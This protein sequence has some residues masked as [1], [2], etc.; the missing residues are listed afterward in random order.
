MDQVLRVLVV[1]DSAYVRKAIKQMLS[2]SPF[3]EVVGIAHDGQ[4]A[5]EMVEQLRPDVVTC[6][7]IM[8]VMDGV[9]FVK[10][11]MS[12]RP[13]PIVVVSIANEGSELAL[14]ALDLGAVDFAQKPT[15]LATEKIFEVSDELIEKVKAAGSVPMARLQTVLEREPPQVSALRSSQAGLVDIVVLGISTGGP[16][17]LKYL[18]PQLPANFP[19]PI[20]MVMHMP[21]GYTEMYA[22]KLNELCEIK[23]SEARE[24]SLITP[25]TVLLAPAGRH[26][27]LRRQANEEVVVHLDARPFDTPHRPSIDVMFQSAADVFGSRTLG[28]VMTGMGADGKQ[29]SAWIKSQGGLIFTE[30]EQSCVVYGMPW[31]VVEAGLSDKS[32]PLEQMAQSILEVV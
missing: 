27:T 30:A 12:R 6:D 19:V 10:E 29:G 24:G 21:V 1:D 14:T 4:E 5:L 11:Q 18:I 20:V 23:V 26:L 15:A 2:R 31:S 9:S 8:P 13:I 25:G 16:Q 22:Q 32:I 28:V 7:L 17:A 3:I